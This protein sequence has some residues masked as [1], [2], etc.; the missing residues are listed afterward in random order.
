MESPKVFYTKC[1]PQG[2]DALELALSINRVFIGYPLHKIEIDES[3]H[4]DRTY[5]FKDVVINISDSEYK[6]ISNYSKKKHGYKSQSSKHHNLANQIKIGSIV[7]IPRIEKGICYAGRVN[8]EFELIDNPEWL[9]YYYKLRKDQGLEYSGLHHATDVIQ[10]WSVEKWQEISFPAIPRWI[11][12]RLF[13]RNTAGII[14]DLK[15]PKIS[16]HSVLDEI[17]DLPKEKQYKRIQNTTD[18]YESLLNWTTPRS[19]E[20]LMISLLQCEAEEGESWYLVGG[21]GDG[22]VDGI[23]VNDH[24]K[25]I[26]ALQCKLFNSKSTKQLANEMKSKVANNSECIV[27]VLAGNNESIDIEGVEVMGIDKIVDLIGKHQN[28]LPI[29]QTLN[30]LDSRSRIPFGNP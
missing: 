29:A 3:E 18:I 16:A 17:I 28:Q 4:V 27:A 20:P 8:S 24:G 22:G 26:K 23:A 11:S 10:T 2:C 1:R 14:H 7:L 9:N 30:I 25:M 21:S 5:G 6:S 13:S 12:Y 19:F 15:K